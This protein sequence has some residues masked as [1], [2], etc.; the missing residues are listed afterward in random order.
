M[1][2][3]IAKA[4]EKGVALEIQAGS[5]YPKPAFLRLAKAM[6]AKFSFGSNN[7]DDK[8][9]DLSRWFEAIRLLDLHPSD[10]ASPK[11]P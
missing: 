8:T 11:A 9:K 3:V 6:G 7:F 4:V 5:E 2:Q 10:L 1:R